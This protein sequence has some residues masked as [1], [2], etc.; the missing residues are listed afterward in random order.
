MNIC[1]DKYLYL[2][3]MNTAKGLLD[4]AI[5]LHITFLR[6]NQSVFQNICTISLPQL[7]I[8]DLS[9]VFFCPFCFL[10]ISVTGSVIN[11][12]TIGS[13]FSNSLSKL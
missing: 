4:Y 8:R 12:I 2:W 9:L 5:T 1:V 3:G 6:N 13:H 11:M 10:L 7:C